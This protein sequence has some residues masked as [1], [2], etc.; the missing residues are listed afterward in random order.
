MAP[1]QSNPSSRR[2]GI[3][4]GT[5]LNGVYEIE[6]LLAT[7]GMGEIYKGHAIQTGDPVAIKMIRPDL[8][9]NEAAIALFTKEAAALHNLYHE[10]IVR[11]YVFTTDPVIGC[12]Y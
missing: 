5:R 11:Y 9:E 12:P 6:S 3:P 7:G 4:P 10:A 8:A 1:H 2:H